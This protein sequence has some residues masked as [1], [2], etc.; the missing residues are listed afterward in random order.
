MILFRI[1]YHFQHQI[2]CVRTINKTQQILSGFTI[3]GNSS[4][5]IY[6]A[7]PFYISPKSSRIIIGTNYVRKSQNYVWEQIFVQFIFHI[8][9]AHQFGVAIS[10]VFFGGLHVSGIGKSNR[11]LFG[12]LMAFK[13]TIL[14]FCFHL[15]LLIFFNFTSILFFLVF[16]ASDTGFTNIVNGISGNKYVL[17]NY[18]FK[19]IIHRFHILPFICTHIYD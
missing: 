16:R 13:N 6:F 5:F 1:F 11:A 7:Y 12:N 17:I 10:L 18:T 8:F 14:P 19:A 9:F 2:D 15:L 3:V 4:L